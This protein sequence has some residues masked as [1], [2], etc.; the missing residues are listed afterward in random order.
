[1]KL[2]N[3]KS[4][5]TNDYIRQTASLLGRALPSSVMSAPL[6][7]SNLRPARRPIPTRKPIASSTVYPP[8]PSPDRAQTRGQIKSAPIASPPEQ[9][10]E[11]ATAQNGDTETERHTSKLPRSKKRKKQKKK[12][13]VRKETDPFG[14]TRRCDESGAR[15]RPE[16]T[17]PRTEPA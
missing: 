9:I 10:K 12:I 17:T 11:E 13:K 2:C 15:A 6:S 5:T 1:M 8:P 4:T 7:S 16:E 3:F 14:N